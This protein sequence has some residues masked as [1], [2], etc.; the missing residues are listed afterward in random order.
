MAYGD[1]QD[2]GFGT[3]TGQGGFTGGAQMHDMA[4]DPTFAGDFGASQMADVLDAAADAVGAGQGG[5]SMGADYSGLMGGNVAE[6][7]GESGFELANQGLNQAQQASTAASN[8][9]QAPMEVIQSQMANMS[10]QPSLEEMQSLLENAGL[11][12]IST[13]P[14]DV[15][16]SGEAPLEGE[17]PVGLT[18]GEEVNQFITEAQGGQSVSEKLDQLNQTASNLQSGTGFSTAAGQGGF[19][20]GSQMFDMGMD[21]T[22]ANTGGWGVPQ[23]TVN[24]LTG[25]QEPTLTQRMQALRQ[26]QEFEN[27]RLEREIAAIK[28]LNEQNALSVRASNVTQPLPSEWSQPDEW[29]MENARTGWDQDVLS[30]QRMDP[31]A[32]R[33]FEIQNPSPLESS[34]PGPIASHFPSPLMSVAD[35]PAGD[36]FGMPDARLPGGDALATAIGAS[37]AFDEYDIP[38]R[39]QQGVAAGQQARTRQMADIDA[40]MGQQDRPRQMAEIDAMIAEDAARRDI[41]ADTTACIPD[42]DI[43]VSISDAIFALKQQ[44]VNMNSQDFQTIEQQLV[45][46]DDPETVEGKVTA[47]TKQSSKLNKAQ[48]KANMDKVRARWQARVDYAQEL[49]DKLD[50]AVEKAGGGWKAYLTKEVGAASKEYGRY[51][52]SDEYGMANGRLNPSMITGIATGG[53]TK[54]G[55]M[56]QDIFHSW[57]K[58]DPRSPEQIAKDLKDGRN[59]YNGEDYGGAAEV[60]GPGTVDWM[61]SNYPWARNLPDEVLRNAIKYPDYL[62]LIL[63][64]VADGK[65]IPLT[66]PDYILNPVIN[67][68]T[69]TVTGTNTDTGTNG[70]GNHPA[71]QTRPSRWTKPS[72]MT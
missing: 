41:A 55:N 40:I 63:N 47:V 9:T 49:K 27:Q 4:A 3:R 52:R 6:Q 28:G 72:W 22:F 66:V 44:G 67:T 10:N 43:D 59:S 8:V 70:F 64:S 30:Q 65:D 37:Q 56:I 69:N 62:R 21:P 11:T 20:G 5:V 33:N 39:Q 18:P 24:M 2:F 26:Q 42:S 19:T 38:S 25:G 54:I 12:G 1:E 71:L 51:I 46:D 17:D 32:R 34:R 31:N 14:Q 68:T 7:Q 23:T 53:A 13:S 48:K 58:T 57:G 29:G 45:Y 36:E 50:K 15:M 35:Y 60:G 16:A 61:R